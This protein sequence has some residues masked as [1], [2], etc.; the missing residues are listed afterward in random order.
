MSGLPLMPS[1]AD[2]VYDT[3]YR[4]WIHDIALDPA[5]RPVIVFAVF[6]SEFDHRY[7]Y[8]RWTGSAWKSYGITSAGGSISDSREPHYSGGITLDHENP[9][10]VYLSREV[11]GVHEVE[12]WRTPDGGRSWERSALTSGSGTENVRPISPRGLASFADDMSVVWMRGRYDHYVAYATDITTRLLN[13]GNLPP[14][15]ESST[16]PRSGRAPLTVSVDGRASRD[17]DGAIATWRWGFGDGTQ[18][19]GARASHTYRAPGR[20][21][22][23]LTVTDEAGDRDAIVSELVVR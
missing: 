22:V 9:S 2:K 14:L 5:G 23:K 11:D 18:G 16:S 13:G 1:E 20:Y 4:S 21:F 12:T 8:A 10:V 7:R 3:R 15:A 19:N 17:P 6:A